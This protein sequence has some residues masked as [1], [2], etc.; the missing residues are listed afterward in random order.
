M[1]RGALDEDDLPSFGED[2]LGD[3]KRQRLSSKD[4]MFLVEWGESA[5]DVDM[6]NP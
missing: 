2:S 5:F 4:D 3:H 6:P 1:D